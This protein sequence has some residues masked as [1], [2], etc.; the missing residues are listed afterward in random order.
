MGT[1]F[2]FGVHITGSKMHGYGGAATAVSAV[3]RWS[4]VRDFAEFVADKSLQE[5]F[6]FKVTGAA[7]D[8]E[9]IG[10]AQKETTYL[11]RTM[12]LP[13]KSLTSLS[14]EPFRTSLPPLLEEV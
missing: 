12:E 8:F 5:V 14:L 7:R 6:V 4:T 11:L 1:A 9:V 2:K 13:R 10:A 3:S